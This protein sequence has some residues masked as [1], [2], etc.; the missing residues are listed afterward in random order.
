MSAPLQLHL[1]SRLSTWLQWIGQRQLRDETRNIHV[2][3][4]GASCIRGLTIYYLI[5]PYLQPCAYRTTP[6]SRTRLLYEFIR[7]SRQVVTG[8]FMTSLKSKCRHLNG[9]LITIWARNWHSGNVRWSPRQIFSSNHSNGNVDFLNDISPIANL[10]RYYMIYFSIL[11]PLWV[12][13]LR[14]EPSIWGLSQCLCD[15]NIGQSPWSLK[16]IRIHYTLMW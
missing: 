8:G 9:I 5:L 7:W 16:I 2:L 13:I 12:G 14:K 4:F 10:N 6:T 15:Q 1:H 11:T 3:G